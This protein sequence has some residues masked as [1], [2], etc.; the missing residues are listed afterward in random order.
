MKTHSRST[1]LIIGA[2]AVLGAFLCAGASI[3]SAESV[4]IAPFKIVLNAQGNSDDVQAIVG[5]VLPSASIVDFEVTLSLDGEENVVALAESAFYCAIDDNLIV[6]FDRTELQANPV[7][8][9]LAGQTVVA[10]V[11][12][13]VTVEYVNADGEL[14]SHTREFSGSDTVEIVAPGNKK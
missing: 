14:V 5:M 3:A 8:V 2:L 9:G 7:V 10:T 4:K 12:G 13:Y 1:V 6:G 11:D